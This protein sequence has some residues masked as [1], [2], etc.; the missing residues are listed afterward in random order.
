[1]PTLPATLSGG[2]WEGSLSVAPRAWPAPALDCSPVP[3][4]PGP[5]LRVAEDPEGQP[6]PLGHPPSPAELLFPFSLLGVVVGDMQFSSWGWLLGWR[7]G[8]LR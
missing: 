5:R 1:M 4:A 2:A 7:E 3:T 6:C 8:R